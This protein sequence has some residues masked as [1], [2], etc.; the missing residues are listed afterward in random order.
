MTERGLR[1]EAK[2]NALDACFPLISKI[3]D[4]KDLRQLDYRQLLDLA[5]EIRRFLIKHV[6]ATGGHLGP[7]LGVVELTLAM[8]LVFKSPK[9]PIIFDTGHQSYVHKILTG[10]ADQFASLRQKDGL[11]GYPSREESEHDWVENSHAS[12]SLSWAGGIARGFWLNGENDRTVAALIGDGALTGGMAWEALDNIAVEDDLPLV[13]IVNDN[14]RSYSPTVG[15]LSRQLSGFRTDPRYEGTLNILRKTVKGA[16][17]IGQSLF[18]LLHGLK[19]GIK[20][21]LAPQSLFSDLGIKYL[22][23]INGHNLESLAVALQQAKNYGGPIIVHVITQKGKG[24]KAAEEF[25]EDL[26]HSVG[27]IDEVTGQKLVADNGKSWTDVFSD[28]IVKIGR[29][30][31][32]VVGITAA[33]LHPVGLANFAEEF[34]DRTFD[35]GIAEQHAVTFSAGLAA[36]GMHPVVA[37]YSTFLNRAFDQ[38]LMDVALHKAGVTF[39]LDRSGVTGSDGASHNGMWDVPLLSIVPGLKLAS[40][41]DEQRLRDAL[42]AAVE[43]DDAPTVIRYSKEKLPDPIP[44]L[45][46]EG[47][48]DYLVEN[49]ES[50]ALIVCYGQFADMAIEAARLLEEQGIAVTVVNPLWALPVSDELVRLAEGYDYVATIEDDLVTGG[51]GEQL[52]IACIQPKMRHFGVPKKFLKHASR[53]QILE[54]CGLTA[55][56]V[57]EQIKNDLAG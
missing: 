42:S 44:A 30:K 51:L 57:A 18:E 9:D 5:E 34:P 35:V 23:P 2:R 54:E 41:R 7:N 16:P 27:K 46:S 1:M 45:K 6:S 48:I 20:D 25:S 17:L 3:K 47:G 32:N 15:G 36:A 12:T 13:I 33:M 49:P 52:E 39:V 55:Q 56:A 37:L 50:R 11:S 28:E 19:A 26:F 53:S 21:V 4:P 22:G 29:E 8:H 24:F 43:I 31:K 10:R 14:G 40:P 38:V